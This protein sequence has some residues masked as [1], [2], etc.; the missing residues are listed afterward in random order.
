MCTHYKALRFFVHRLK[1]Q[2]HPV[3]MKWLFGSPTFLLTSCV[4]VGI[5]AIPDLLGRRLNLNPNWH[6]VGK[7]ELQL[8]IETF[9]AKLDTAIVLSLQS[10]LRFDII[11]AIW[12]RPTIQMEF[13]HI[14][15]FK[16]QML[17]LSK[18]HASGKTVGN[19]PIVEL[20]SFI[21]I[22]SIF[23]CMERSLCWSKGAGHALLNC[24]TLCN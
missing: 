14:P 13:S 18:L 11:P 10:N 17:G 22:R 6:K 12:M 5:H 8:E 24:T 15:T 21:C 9:E 23:P 16:F 19:S 4:M 1:Y 20:N 7:V 3:Y 2:I